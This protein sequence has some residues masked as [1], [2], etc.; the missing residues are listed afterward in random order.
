MD[1]PDC[2]KNSFAQKSVIRMPWTQIIE[3]AQSFLTLSF[4]LYKNS[5]AQK[6]V[7][8]TPWT[9]ITEATQSFLTLSFSLSP[10]AATRKEKHG[11]QNWFGQV[12]LSQG[13]I[14]MV[15][16]TGLELERFNSSR[17]IKAWLSELVGTG[18]DRCNPIMVI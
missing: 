11:C 6:S 5:F 3:G 8:R 9:Q 7:I 12:Q 2:N 14:G 17:V 10:K 16:R 4:L 15:V 1:P 18:L 13:Y